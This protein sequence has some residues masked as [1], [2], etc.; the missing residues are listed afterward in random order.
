MASYAAQQ[1][2]AEATQEAK[3]ALLLAELVSPDPYDTDEDDEWFAGLQIPFPDDVQADRTWRTEPIATNRF[4]CHLCIAGFDTEGE[5]SGH[6]QAKHGG[7]AL[8]LARQRY[9]EGRR[10]P[11]T[12]GELGRQLV[13]EYHA[14]LRSFKLTACAVCA[15]T[16]FE[17]SQYMTTLAWCDIQNPEEVASLLDPT[18]YC[19][20][21]VPV[22]ELQRA[23]IWVRFR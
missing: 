4:P 2:Q 13:G 17:H 7:L 1:Q 11:S 14:H 12:P 21:K 8:Y 9:H 23:S 10:H 19:R 15:A 22:A 16:E 3:T 18:A 20:D 6:I 5:L